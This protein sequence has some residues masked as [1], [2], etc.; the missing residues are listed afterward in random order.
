MQGKR[1]SHIAGSLGVFIAAFFG[2]A[3]P[4]QMAFAQTS[5]PQFLITWQASNSYVPASYPGKILP[6]QESQISAS[7]ELIV[8]G[9]PVNLSGQTIYWYSNDN[10]LG[11]GVG[12]SRVRFH[13][14]ISAPDSLTLKVELPNYPGGL[15]VHE[16]N[17]PIVQPQ[18]VIEAPY[19][20]GRFSAIPIM[21][22]ALPYFWNASS[23]SPLS[24]AWSVNG[25]TV[26]SPENP[27]TLQISLP[28][29]TQAGFPVS[30]TL[31]MQN[32]NDS[33]SATGN[34]NLTYQK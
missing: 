29:S 14:S 30:I 24:F 10:A 16:I 33:M 17:I 27:E 12:A 3:L 15:L 8:Q 1:F 4:L 23:V 22:Q 19:P 9:R 2:M 28:Q 18:A 13:P 5:Q 26:Q 21:V 25:Q 31:S 6:N 11:G 20:Q 34:A 7:L 32:A